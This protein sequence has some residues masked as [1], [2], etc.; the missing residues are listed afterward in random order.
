MTAKTRALWAL[1]TAHGRPCCA[2]AAQSKAPAPLSRNN[3][4]ARRRLYL[5]AVSPR[6]QPSWWRRR[7]CYLEI[8][9][10]QSSRWRSLNFTPTSSRPTFWKSLFNDTGSSNYWLKDQN[11]GK[12]GKMEIINS[13]KITNKKECHVIKNKKQTTEK[14]KNGQK[15]NKRK[16]K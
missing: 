13:T 2:A 6:R 16:N 9:L 10:E 15:T 4:S 8:L 14:N 1:R 7:K 12:T 11:K 5:S 3:S